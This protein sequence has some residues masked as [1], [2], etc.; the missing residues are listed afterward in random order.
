MLRKETEI[1]SAG[2]R[3]FSFV[4]QIGFQKQD[5]LSVPFKSYP[6][7]GFQACH[8]RIGDLPETFPGGNIRKMHFCRRNTYPF[9]RVQNGYARMSIGGRVDDNAVSLS[10]CGL[11]TVYDSPFVIGLEQNRLYPF[12]VAA[13][14]DK[15]LKC[16]II[17]SMLSIR[18]FIAN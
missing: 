12:A 6:N 8:P 3:F 7:K 15:L 11:N 10:I 9:Q 5:R 17:C 2:L 16:L 13:V 18:K 1:G 4:F 14:K